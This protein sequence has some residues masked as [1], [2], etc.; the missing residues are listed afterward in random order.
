MEEHI[1]EKS[2][3]EYSLDTMGT[4][5]WAVEEHL[6]ICDSC[7]Q[8]LE[9]IEPFNYVHFTADGPIYS[10]LTRLPNGAIMA[11]HWGWDL[12]GGRLW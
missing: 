9:A 5:V 11:R 8:R 10:R 12:Q 4:S 2:L 7:R 1:P 6:L 3:E